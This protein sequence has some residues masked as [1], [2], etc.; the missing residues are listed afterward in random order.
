[1]MVGCCHRL[2]SEHD[3]GWPLRKDFGAKRWLREAYRDVQGDRAF[4]FESMG[5][6][7]IIAPSD[8][9]TG[10]STENEPR[11][12]AKS[13]FTLFWAAPVT[14]ITLALE[15]ECHVRLTRYVDAT[16]ALANAKPATMPNRGERK[17]DFMVARDQENH[18]PVRNTRL[19]LQQI[20][21]TVL[22]EVVGG[23]GMPHAVVYPVE[24]LPQ[25][26][27]KDL[28]LFSARAIDTAAAI[29]RWP[30]ARSLLMDP[31]AKSRQALS[32]R[33]TFF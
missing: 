2:T 22:G 5:V 19:I 12:T 9:G 25:I 6:Q 31:Y 23:P 17:T 18:H 29:S 10:S 7:R 28:D 15:I 14:V 16:S 13:D 8:I 26:V 11:H 21:V 4:G 1:M 30:S 24:G 3:A 20:E 33:W 27:A 32:P